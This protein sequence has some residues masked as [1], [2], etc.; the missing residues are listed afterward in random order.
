[1]ARLT[2]IQKIGHQPKDILN[3]QELLRSRKIYWSLIRSH[4]NQWYLTRS[5]ETSQDIIRSQNIFWDLKR[6]T[7]I[8]MLACWPFMFW[9]CQLP[10]M[11]VDGTT[12]AQSMTIAR[13]AIF[14][15]FL[16][17]LWRYILKI[18]TYLDI[19]WRYHIYDK[20]NSKCEKLK[21]K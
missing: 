4:R 10:V 12:L 9:K 14:F 15:S 2:S 8:D 18:S 16:I 19:Y 20:V 21:L 7:E 17:C 13:W 5:N 11:T 1:M 3:S 6:S